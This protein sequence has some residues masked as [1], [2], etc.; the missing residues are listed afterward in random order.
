M[1][2]GQIAGATRVIGERQGY[3]GLPLKDVQLNSTV[4]QCGVCGG[5]GTVFKTEAG[6]GGRGVLKLRCER[7]RGTGL[8]R[9]GTGAPAPAM[10]T[11]WHPTPAELDRLCKGAAVILTVLGTGHP[12]VMLDVGEAPPAVELPA[13]TREPVFVLP[14]PGCGS[15]ATCECGERPSP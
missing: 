11:A 1:M 10:Q 6:P 7:C 9:S 8:H 4:V 13:V 3:L 5:T 15:L 14:C 12:P 2:I